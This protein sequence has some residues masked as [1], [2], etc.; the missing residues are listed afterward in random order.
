MNEDFCRNCKYFYAECVEKSSGGGYFYIEC[1]ANG[2]CK[3][4]ED[5]GV[6]E[7][8]EYETRWEN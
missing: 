3:F 6:W 4:N 1:E 8:E 7:C 5:E 2:E